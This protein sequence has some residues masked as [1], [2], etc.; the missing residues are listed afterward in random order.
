M[1]REVI[2]PCDCCY[3]TDLF[4]DVCEARANRAV[5][6]VDRTADVCEACFEKASRYFVA[7]SPV[8]AVMTL[9]EFK[10]ALLLEE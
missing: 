2:G 1:I 8:L 4:C 3:H 5:M 10:I 6:F 7:R 9:D